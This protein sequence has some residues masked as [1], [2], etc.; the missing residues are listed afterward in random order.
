MKKNLNI[1]VIGNGH[2]CLVLLH[3]FEKRVVEIV[4]ARIVAI[5]D[6]G[7]DASSEAHAGDRG[8]LVTRDLREVLSRK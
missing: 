2:K 8:A 3:H 1:A 5:V 7:D 6:T 4:H